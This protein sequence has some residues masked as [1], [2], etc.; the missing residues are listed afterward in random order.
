FIAVEP[1]SEMFF[2][3][4]I[5]AREFL[6]GQKRWCLWLVDAKPAEL[7]AM[8][9][10]LKRIEAI[11]MFRLDS[12]RKQTVEKAETPMLFGEIR[13]FGETY[14]VVPA[15]TSENRKY[16]PMSLFDTKSIANN[17]CMVIP[18]GSLYHFGMLMSSLN[19]AWVNSV[20]GRLESR[21]RYSKDIV[22][23][24]FPWAEN[25]TEKQIAKI[26]ECAQAVLDARQVFE[27]S[28]LADLY[29]PITMPPALVK[30]HNA[31]DRAVD[32]AYR[33]TP[34]TTATSRI[35]F[36]FDLYEKYNA[37]LFPECK[38]KK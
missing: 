25:P 37:T 1:K 5:S 2:K 14:I 8:P 15:H 22:Y 3:P 6:N 30:A 11:K 16:I 20:C 38:K 31:L 29:D 4:L 17:S 26:E 10:V 9:N 35:E 36:L 18:N 28:S 23:N 7:R 21:L 32:A 27:G 12:T 33:S 24:N 13:D 19:M 34:F